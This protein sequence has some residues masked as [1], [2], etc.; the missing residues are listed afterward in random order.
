VFSL[1]GGLVGLWAAALVAFALTIDRGH[2]RAFVTADDGPRFARALFR[3]RAGDA[4]AAA[5]AATALSC[6]DVAA[7]GS[8]EARC[9]PHLRSGQ[10][11]LGPGA[12][13][14]RAG[15]GCGS[16]R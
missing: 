15:C 3:A 1:L 10:I 6:A 9:P 4:A 14:P 11:C 16:V 8:R 13:V 5:A 12:D 2:L 7:L